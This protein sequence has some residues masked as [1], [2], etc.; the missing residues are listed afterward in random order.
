M[1][2]FC[3]GTEL[4]LRAARRSDFSALHL[5]IDWYAQQGEMLAPDALLREWPGFLVAE[6]DSG[7][8]GCGRLHL[9]SDGSAEIR[10]LAVHPLK[11]GRGIGRQIVENLEQQA[12]SL[13]RSSCF[14]LT[15]KPGFFQRLGYEETSRGGFVAKEA[16]DC[17]NCSKRAECREVTLAKY[18][19]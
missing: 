11:M 17:L 18:L 13:G 1:L 19:I 9:W 2:A 10:S 15:L 12:R 8:V 4:L 7:L 16:G 14:A 6:D 3:E 5:L